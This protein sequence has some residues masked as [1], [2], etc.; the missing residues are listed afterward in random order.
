MKNIFPKTKGQLF[1]FSKIHNSKSM[2]SRTFWLALTCLEIS[3]KIFYIFFIIVLEFF[4]K[5]PY[6][7]VEILSWKQH[8]LEFEPLVFSSK[9]LWV[10]KNIWNFF[11][12]ISKYFGTNKNVLDPL[13]F[14]LWIFQNE[15]KIYI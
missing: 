5:R 15:K 4:L 3:K 2:G 14:E 6:C 10:L 7:K 13:L 8:F 9:E 12:D 1:S 11:F